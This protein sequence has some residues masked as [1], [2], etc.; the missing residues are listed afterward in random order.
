MCLYGHV[1][2]TD[3][4]ILGASTKTREYTRID[5]RKHGWES[6]TLGSETKGPSGPLE[7]SF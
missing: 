4:D 1:S 7:R 3:L 5:R 6:N 2:E